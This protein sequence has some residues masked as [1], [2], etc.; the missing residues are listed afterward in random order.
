M[1]VWKLLP[2]MF[3]KGDVQLVLL[4]GSQAESDLIH[5]Y[6]LAYQHWH[7]IWEGH[8]KERDG[9]KKLYSDNFTRQDE[10][11]AFFWKDICLGAT[12]NRGVDFNRAIFRDDSY[13]EVWDQESF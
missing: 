7:D 1:S 3:K 2:T 5:Y 12:C 13:F 10:I 9:I 11:C 6:D 8:F 4:N